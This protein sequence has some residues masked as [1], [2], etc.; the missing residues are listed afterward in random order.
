[1]LRLFQGLMYAA[2]G[3]QMAS[4]AGHDGGGAVRALARTD[5]RADELVVVLPLVLLMV[6]LG[7]YPYLITHA[8]PALGFPL[9]VAWR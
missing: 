6:L 9:P 5:I 7:L 3:E 4:P 2:P 8:M 1:M